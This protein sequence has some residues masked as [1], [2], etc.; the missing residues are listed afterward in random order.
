MTTGQHLSRPV[1][2]RLSLRRRVAGAVLAAAAAGCSSSAASNPTTSS[3]KAPTSSPASTAATTA[4]TRPAPAPAP[5]PSP[6]NTIWLCEPGTADDPCAPNLDT[7]VVQANGSKSRVQVSEASSTAVDCFY[8]YPTVSPEVTI[9]SNLAIQPAEVAAAMEQAAQFSQVCRV[10]AP[11]YRQETTK[12]LAEEGLTDNPYEQIAYGSVLSAWRDYLAHHND[13]RPVVFIGHSQGAAMLID[14]LR[15][16]VDPNPNVRKLLVSALIIGG[17]VEV[18]IGKVVGSTFKH[19]PACQLASQTG[20]VIAYSSFSSEPPPPSYFGRPGQGVSLQSGQTEKAGVQVLCV[21]PAAMGGGTGAL[22]PI[23][24]AP[25]RVTAPWVE[26]PGL[27]SATCES[28]GGATWLNIEVNTAAVGARPLVSDP[29]G[30]NWGLH[31]S[32]VNLAL[33]NLVQIV[34]TEASS[35][36]SG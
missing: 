24:A 2:V 16:Q 21:N 12:G 3:T 1:S 11:M 15:S 7:T 13:G 5:S 25:K 17:N 28:S 9:N 18:P 4:T 26:Y 32:D 6:A 8:V 27:Y 20:C 22:E 23:F 31:L 33:G 14:L 10:W 30:P 29:L 19:I 34:K 36:Q 35:F